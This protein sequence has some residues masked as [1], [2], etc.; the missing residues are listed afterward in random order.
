M[1]RESGAGTRPAAHTDS[2]AVRLNYLFHQT[3]PDSAAFDLR[4]DRLMAT[5]KRLEDVRNVC[6]VDPYAA[7]FDGDPY[8][9]PFLPFLTSRR[10]RADTRPT[11]L[12]VILDRITDEIL[13]GASQRSTVTLDRW[14]LSRDQGF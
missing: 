10:L 7:I 13:H 12:P 11:V 3:E 9:V 5:V 14:H 2:A 6:G 1:N 4:G 8:F